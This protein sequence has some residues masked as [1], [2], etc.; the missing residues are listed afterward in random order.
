M[1][2]CRRNESES[3]LSPGPSGPAALGD[4]RT[5]VPASVGRA[6]RFLTLIMTVAFGLLLLQAAIGLGP[7]AQATIGR[8]GDDIVVVSATVLCLLRMVREPD[9]RDAWLFL[10]LALGTWSFGTLYQ[11]LALWDVPRATASLGDIGWLAIYPLSLLALLSF[12][13]HQIGRLDL[14]LGIDVVIGILALLAFV[15][16]ALQ[17]ML[18]ES[19]DP[20][21]AAVSVA[22]PV[23]DLLLVSFSIAIG[24]ANGWRMDRLWLILLSGFLVTVIGDLMYAADI[25]YATASGASTV[26]LLWSCGV[27]LIGC[28]TWIPTPPALDR[29]R[30]AVAIGLPIVLAFGALALVVYS[31][32]RPVGPVSV[33]LAAG[34][35]CACLVRLSLTHRDNAVLLDQAEEHAHVDALTGLGNRRAF[36]RDAERLLAG[37]EPGH[38]LRLALFDLDGF[39]RYNDRDG[40]LAGDELLAR[41]SGQLLEAVGGEGRCYRLGG[42][43]FCLIAEATPGSRDEL[44]ARAAS[45]LADDRPEVGVESS[46]GSVVIRPGMSLTAA[47][48]LADERMYAHKD[49]RRDAPMAPVDYVDSPGDRRAAAHRRGVA[50]PAPA[51]VVPPPESAAAGEGKHGDASAPA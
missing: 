12:A 37:L 29:R 25:A 17:K 28:A 15:A 51:G 48:R 31:S 3:D 50:G 46:H 10:S 5:P 30:S 35:L 21:T 43:E 18:A 4:W 27:A 41:F 1:G 24:S 9:Q 42:D 19:P 49:A 20:L 34:S 45:A 2:L 22:Y 7:G 11:S 8:F 23:G 47:L 6:R 44:T 14:R 39:K 33:L 16:G 13:R 32:L 40:H 38:E 26:A 36:A